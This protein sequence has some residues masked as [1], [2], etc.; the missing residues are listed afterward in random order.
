[1]GEAGD[2]VIATLD[3]VV[4]ESIPEEWAF[5]LRIKERRGWSPWEELPRQREQ[6]MERFCHLHNCLLRRTLLLCPFYRSG[7]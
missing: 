1:M 7:S 2:E 5:Q 4:R 6:S 3:G